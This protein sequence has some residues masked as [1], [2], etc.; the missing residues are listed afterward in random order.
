[1][2]HSPSVWPWSSHDRLLT[3]EC[4]ASSSPC[5]WFCKPYLQWSRTKPV[6]LQ[7]RAGQVHASRVVSEHRRVACGFTLPHALYDCSCRFILPN[8]PV[9]FHTKQAGGIQRLKS[10]LQRKTMGS[11]PMLGKSARISPSVTT[12][13]GQQAFRLCGEV[14]R[15]ASV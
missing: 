4:S 12:N 8:T 10:F 11:K 3:C 9:P 15:T 6:P 14:I 2:R 5:S 1:M 13:A 7:S